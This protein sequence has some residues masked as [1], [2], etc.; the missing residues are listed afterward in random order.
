ML[1][2]NSLNIK[3]VE[4]LQYFT[5]PAKYYHVL[6]PDK[7]VFQDAVGMLKEGANLG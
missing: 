2:N 1:F 5:K 3:L 6:Q 7:C 4:L